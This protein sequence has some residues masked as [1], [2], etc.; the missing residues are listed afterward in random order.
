MILGQLVAVEAV[1]VMG[2]PMIL[3]SW[4]ALQSSKLVLFHLY[5][6][7]PVALDTGVL[8]TQNTCYFAVTEVAVAV[9]N[10][11]WM[12]LSIVDGLSHISFSLLYS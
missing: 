9:H 2:Y 4:V 7:Q 12:I 10:E 3:R 1:E 6:G 5:R 11:S 8:L